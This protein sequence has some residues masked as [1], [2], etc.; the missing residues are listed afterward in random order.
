MQSRGGPHQLALAPGSPSSLTVRHQSRHLRFGVCRERTKERKE[1]LLPGASESDVLA[2]AR[3]VWSCLTGCKAHL[4]Q[5]TRHLR[6]QAARDISQSGVSANDSDILTFARKV[7]LNA[8]MPVT[9]QHSAREAADDVSKSGVAGTLRVAA[10]V[11]CADHPCIAVLRS[12]RPAFLL[13]PGRQ[14]PGL[15]GQSKRLCL[16]DPYVLVPCVPRPCVAPSLPIQCLLT[17]G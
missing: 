7:W 1:L 5:N 17:G 8:R 10:I 2:F 9:I 16:P 6:Y 3:K 11:T 12:A 4:A 15:P 13:S 14:G